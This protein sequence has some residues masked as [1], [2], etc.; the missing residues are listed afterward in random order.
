MLGFFQLQA[1]SD[2]F[3][4]GLPCVIMVFPDHTPLLFAVRYV[5]TIFALKM[6]FYKIT[7]SDPFYIG[8]P[9]EKMVVALTDV[10]NNGK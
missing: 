7:R 4:V 10:E 5:Y 9:L 1:F 2:P 3:I 8:G 6:K